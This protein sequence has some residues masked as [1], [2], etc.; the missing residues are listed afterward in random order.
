MF[1][2][3][4]V[5]SILVE[6]ELEHKIIKQKISNL[7]T[8]IS[9]RDFSRNTEKI[10]NEIEQFIKI[11]LIHHQKE[12]ETVYKELMIQNQ[13]ADIELIEKITSDH[14]FLEDLCKSILK[15]L[16]RVLHNL[17]PMRCGAIGADISF[18]INKYNEHYQKEEE[19]IF[20]I[21]G[22]LMS[23]SLP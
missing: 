18:M 2:R 6:L 17:E 15:Q 21:Y 13:G 19:F 20:Q 8:L 7:S 14:R 12:E 10:A 22:N 11:I 4:S 9:E 5:N 1:G 16:I 23:G 3:C